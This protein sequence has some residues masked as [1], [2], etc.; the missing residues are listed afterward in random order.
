MTDARHR[1]RPSSSSRRPGPLGV[2]GACA[3]RAATDCRVVSYS[4]CGDAGSGMSIDPALGFDNYLHQ[5]D[6]VFERTGLSR[7]TLVRRVSYGGFI[8]LRYAATGPSGSAALVLVSAPAPGWRAVPASAALPREAR[9]C[10]RRSSCWRRRRGCGRRSGRRCASW[11]RGCGS[12]SRTARGRVG[13]ARSRQCRGPRCAVQQATD[14]SGD[15]ARVQRADA[16][17]HR[18]GRAR[19]GRAAERSRGGTCRDDPRRAPREARSGR[20]TSACS[21]SRHGS[22]R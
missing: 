20:A 1:D 16:G 19:P 10:S 22:P 4:L 6:A 11:P 8:A 17:H 18:R 2:D 14:F 3:A 15:G 7:A 5:L 9:G 12:R 13:A 21:R